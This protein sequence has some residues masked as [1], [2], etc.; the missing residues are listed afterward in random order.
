[1]LEYSLAIRSEMCFTSIQECRMCLL[2][3]PL[4]LVF[5]RDAFSYVPFEAAESHLERLPV[6]F[7]LSFGIKVRPRPRYRAT[8]TGQD[9]NLPSR[10]E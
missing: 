5:S 1:M 7:G 8:V 2:P 9:R 3:A 6:S 4:P 10:S